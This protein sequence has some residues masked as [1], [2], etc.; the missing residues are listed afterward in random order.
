M[1]NASV[2][3]QPDPEREARPSSILARIE[4]AAFHHAETTALEFG[5]TRLSYAGLLR[6]TDH[7]AAR[8]A[9][10]GVGRDTAVGLHCPRGLEAL[11]AWTAILKSG[12]AIVP[13]DPA[14]PAE[15]LRHMAKV[16][17]IRHIVVPSAEADA[18]GIADLPA[19]RIPISSSRDADTPQAPALPVRRHEDLL[20]ILFTSGSTGTPKGV[21]MPDRV[22]DNLVAWQ[23]TVLPVTPGTRVLQ[24]APGSFDVSFQEIAST[25]AGGG[26]L[27][28]IDED[29]RRDPAA[30]LAVI[31][32]H[33]VERL[34][35]PV[36]ML[37]E[38]VREY[39]SAA[40]PPPLPVRDIITAGEQLRVT[41][42][43]RRFFSAHPQCRLH[44]HYGPTE[45]HVVTAATLSGA[46]DTW[47][48]LPAI[49]API[50]G[51]AIHL[52]D[53]ARRPVADGTEGE[54]YIGGLVLA[55]GYHNDASRTAASFIEI[56]LGDGSGPQRLYRTG[57]LARR[58]PT[59]EFA[60]LGRADDQVKINGFRI[61][62]G[63]VET[64][65]EKHPAV[66][67]CA[68][69]AVAN[70][71]TGSRN[72]AAWVV[73][74]DATTP[75]RLPETLRAFLAE[76]LPP[77]AVPAIIRTI[78][79][80]PRTPSG[81]IDR[82]TLAAGLQD[83]FPKTAPAREGPSPA[84]GGEPLS[85]LQ[86]I[87]SA[88]LHIE[89]IPPHADLF[90]LGANSISVARAAREI[91][92]RTGHRIATARLFE[93]RTCA[94]QA[95][96]IAHT[97][98]SPEQAKSD[99]AEATDA[100]QRAAAPRADAG[101]ED[102]DDFPSDAIAIIGMAGRFPGAASVDDFWSASL[103]G[104][105]LLTRFDPATLIR[106]PEHLRNHPGYVPV[107]GVL[108]QADCFDAAFF[109]ISPR[110]ADLMD[111]QHRV[112]LE[113]CWHALEDAGAVRE[114]SRLI[115]G[116]FAGQS[117]NTYL[118]NNL[119][120][121]RAR[122]DAFLAQHQTGELAT[123][124]GNDK[125][126]LATRVAHKL[127]LRGPA[128]TVQ[129]GCST[130][131]VAVVQAARSLLAGEC[132]MC[133]A[134][135]VSLSF[136]QERGHLHSEG[137]IASRDGTCR[138]FDAD[139]SGTVFGGG[140]GV[141]VLKRLR[142]A[143]AAGDRIHAVIRG[144]AL[145]ND[146]AQ[147]SSFSAPSVEGQRRVITEALRRARVT[148]DTIGYVETHGT[149][150][151]LGDPIELTGL[152]DAFAAA[153]A[154]PGNTCWLG[155]A[156]ANIGH[157]EAAAGIAGLIRAACAVRDGMIP[158]MAHFTR[159]NEHLDLEGTPFRIPTEPTPW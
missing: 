140:A 106:V 119:S 34:F 40:E 113:C 145:N 76:R 158:P 104:L 79:A 97:H 80:L 150:T 120:P 92:R 28:L 13:L 48:D 43:V 116:V 44:N 25:L 154:T 121:D 72:L 93:H 58:L 36:V 1:S 127:D 123:L 19:I 26:T 107:R 139:A 88:I 81:K 47:P 56:D 5:S 55:R 77:H 118:L 74:G 134:G 143:L 62:L 69:A 14:Y 24:F 32:R 8:L 149:G 141:V 21:A 18:D 16:A 71:H 7:L 61:E 146:G 51:A 91:A 50:P 136:P 15:R 112:F 3:N 87:W 54:L 42:A 68:A 94:A 100:A 11:I 67:A 45:T 52:L 108:E 132:D 125:D 142:D 102:S 41:D 86:A 157:L 37:H 115:T 70:P 82:R 152:N 27:V 130:S 110:E 98:P 20:Y 126:F 131:L 144:C 2:P 30:L 111:P 135:G 22:L 124:L 99:T 9:A 153:G 129:A 156:K 49:G 103:A 151:P 12:G 60:Y 122:I 73:P 4:R 137:S 35:L 128:L 64:T 6:Q 159:P 105:D 83:T 66:A 75:A 10:A 148:A 65:L 85:T 17:Q 84:K 138:P 39:L 147:K 155:S 95:A 96:L 133:L 101:I 46:P 29:Q 38:L 59:G 63:E 89:E 33:R 78:D 90:E 117:L 31:R 114:R 23:E 57:D 109:G 53:D